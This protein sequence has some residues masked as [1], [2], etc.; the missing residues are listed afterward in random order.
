MDSIVNVVWFV[1]FGLFECLDVIVGLKVDVMR[2]GEKKA[3][4]VWWE[5]GLYIENR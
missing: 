4:I 1:W 2:R 5:K 3:D